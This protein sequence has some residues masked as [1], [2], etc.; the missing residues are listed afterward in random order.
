MEAELVPALSPLLEGADQWQEIL[1]LLPV[2]VA[3]EAVLSADN[4]IA[5]AAIARRLHDPAR[6][7]QALNLGM[8]LALL[9]RFA[10][11]LAAR[12]V[13]DAWP[14]QLLAAGYLLW[15][16]GRHFL[17]LDA[18]EEE[19]Q[20]A[21]SSGESGSAPG[22]PAAAAALGSLGRVA[23]TLGF[24]DLAFSLDSVAA[25]VAVTD[26][27]A[28]VMLGGAI[29]VVALRLTAGL[30]LRWLEIYS[31]LEAAGYLAVGLVGIRLLLRLALPDLELPEWSLLLIVAA[32]FVWGFSRR[33][34]ALEDAQ[35]PSP[36]P[37][38]RDSSAAEITEVRVKAI[39]DANDEPCN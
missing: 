12:W 32:L 7:R 21:E 30:F 25:A 36:A 33:H 22:Q 31:R 29:G 8:L 1:L 18:E 11:I 4:A 27:L 24:T 3:L 20:D 15:L 37:A 35:P 39:V 9:F 14:L 28:L 5:L 17:Q 16:S 6:Q 2:L 34:P 19:Q 23:L 10:L 13:L 26:R 38:D